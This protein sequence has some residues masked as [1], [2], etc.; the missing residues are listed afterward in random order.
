MKQSEPDSFALEHLSAP[1]RL[2]RNALGA[3]TV[4][5]PMWKGTDQVTAVRRLRRSLDG[6]SG[7]LGRPKA[8]LRGRRV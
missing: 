5:G 8:I 4:S 1:V 2:P 3:W 7:S 6:M